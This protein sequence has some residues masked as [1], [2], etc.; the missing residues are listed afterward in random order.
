MR[1]LVCVWPNCPALQEL[2]STGPT[3]LLDIATE[4]KVAEAVG[5][6]GSAVVVCEAVPRWSVRIE[7]NVKF[8]PLGCDVGSAL[9]QIAELGRYKLD[10]DW[11]WTPEIHA[12][13][14]RMNDPVRWS[15]E[16]AKGDYGDRREP[17][18]S[19]EGRLMKKGRRDEKQ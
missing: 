10:Y 2:N 6:V 9:L 3:V 11:F 15:C 12:L 14:V 16:L 13:H 18:D 7:P 5:A 4:R 19:V 17:D 8:L 1:I